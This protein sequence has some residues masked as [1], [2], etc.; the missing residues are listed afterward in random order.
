M[1][2]FEVEVFFDTDLSR[3]NFALQIKLNQMTTDQLK[4]LKARVDA[5]RRYL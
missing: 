5:L 4:D 2:L 3:Y 1:I